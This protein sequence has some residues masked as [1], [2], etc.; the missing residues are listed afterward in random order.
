MKWLREL[1]RVSYCVYLIHRAV[2]Y[3]VF[4][5]ALRR[6]PGLLDL[7]T[8][9]LTLISAALTYFVASLSWRY[10][11]GPLVKI[12]HRTSYEFADAGPARTASAIP[13]EGS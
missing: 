12:G 8:F 1:G 11:E 9:G 6:L 4:G 13:A 5:L 2:S 10:I 3:L 7:R